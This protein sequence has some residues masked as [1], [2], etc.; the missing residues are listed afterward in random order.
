MRKEKFIYNTH[1]LRYEKVQESLSTRV[2]RIFGVL[3][4]IVL[5][6]GIFTLIAHKWFPSPKEEALQRQI[7]QMEQDYNDVLTNLELLSQELTNLQ[8]R[9]AYA[10]RMIFGMDPIDEGVWEGG[11]GGHDEYA[12]YRQFKES[13]QL[14]SAVSQKVD[15]LKRQMYIQSKSLD[16]IINMAKEKEIMLASIPSIK[17]V[18]SDKLAR[19]VKLLSGFGRRI[20][21]IYKV[22]RMHWGI[23]FT[24]PRNTPIQA[25]G[26]GTVVRV[27]NRST[28]YGKHVVIDHGFGYQT[29]YGH[30]SR[31][32]VKPGQRVTRGQQIGQVGS[33][34]T[35][36]APHCHY[37]VT[38][39]GQKVNPIHYCMD[40]LSPEEYQELV[41]AAEMANQSM[42]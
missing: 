19:S 21:P 4:A 39:R 22:P 11:I 36:T 7:K 33:T 5:T 31:I 14:M 17:P 26:A 24:A 8:E 23:D 40:G 42:D 28:G 35:S 37:E 27:E 3:C 9:D 30:M 2:L 16:T 38:F 20:H 10:H 29:L 12:K 13:G 6:A 18:R 1:T 34:G 15:K 41:K 25:T 32:D